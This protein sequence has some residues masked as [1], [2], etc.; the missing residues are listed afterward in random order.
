MGNKIS[1]SLVAVAVLLLMAGCGLGTGSN[2]DSGGTAKNSPAVESRQTNPPVV[3][4]GNGQTGTS[5]DTEK[6]P[7]AE[8]GKAGE[9]GSGSGDKTGIVIITENK[10]PGQEAGQMLEEVDRQLDD[11]LKA[12]DV[13]EDIDEKE[14]Q[15]EGGQ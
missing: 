1:R 2:N 10:I 12:L 3:D 5:G 8:G 11:L 15:N 9:K 14:L 7:G 4:P 13:A 6:S